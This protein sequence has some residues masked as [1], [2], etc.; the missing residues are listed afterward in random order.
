MTIQDLER[1]SPAGF[2]DIKDQL[3]ELVYARSEEAFERGNSDRDAI[4][5]MEDVKKRQK[6]VRE[7]FIDAIGGLPPS[8]ASLNAKITGTIKCDG[9]RIEKVIFESRPQN[10]VTAN[11]YIPDS[12]TVP[13]AAVQFLCGHSSQAKH[14]NDYHTVCLYLVKSGLVV[15]AQD[16]VGQGERFSYYEN[17]IGK[18]TIGEG[19]SEHS[20]AGCQCLPVG[21]ASARYFVHDAMRGIDY[22]CSR[23]EVDS[24]R[25]GVT[26]SSGGGTQTSMMIVWLL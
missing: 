10:Y 25:I 19:T 14:S 13:A 23:P 15:M 24:T 12:I 17:S 11:L 26:G 16:P 18:N 6:M 5:S 4:K 20:Y 1:Y 9:F 7:K 21:D 3:K 8:D 22:L 2:Y